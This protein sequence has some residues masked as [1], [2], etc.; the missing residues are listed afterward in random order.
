MLHA[1][2]CAVR[3][4][5]RVACVVATAV[6]ATPRLARRRPRPGREVPLT[7]DSIMRGPD[8]VGYPPT[9]SAG[10]RIRTKLYF[11]WR[12]PGE[13][14]A[15]TYV[16][17]RDGGAPVKLTDDQKKS[18][19]PANG[20][21]DKAHRRV[22]LRRSRRH[23]AARR[24]R[25]APAD[26]EDHRRREQSALG[27]PRHGHHLRARRQPVPRSARHRSDAGA[28]RAA[29]HRRRRR[30]RRAAADRQPEVHA[31]RRREAARGGRGAEGQEEEGGGQG[32]ART[33]CRTF[34]L[35]DRQSARRSDA[36]A[37][38]HARLRPRRRAPGRRAQRRSSRTT[39]TRRATP[40]TSRGARPSATRRIARCS[41][42]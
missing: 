42:S 20:R 37:G 41:R 23:R 19:P 22:A 17:G 11:E 8:L 9:A 32:Q 35:Q 36:L 15:S 6:V 5:L 3:Y 26:H 30:R 39:S 24:R 1:R 10:R 14:E 4:A 40:K 29:A 2:S 18:A 31:R 13:D 27:A 7:V 21:W 16:V 28:D 12:K 33:S 25:H 34:E 38:R